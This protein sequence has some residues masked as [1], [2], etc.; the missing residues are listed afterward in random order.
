VFKATRLPPSAQQAIDRRITIVTA[1]LSEFL[2]YISMS[3]QGRCVGPKTSRFGYRI[4]PSSS[5]LS[6]SVADVGMD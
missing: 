2:T 4:A 3:V 5:F 1:R 6:F